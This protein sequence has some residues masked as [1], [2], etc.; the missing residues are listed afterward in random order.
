MIKTIT[1]SGDIYTDSRGKIRFVNGFNFKGVKRFYQIENA[2]TDIVRAFHGHKKEEKFVYV[3]LG[4]IIFCAVYIA[5]FKKP[6]KKTVVQRYILTHKKPQVIYVPPHFANGFRAL[7]KKT[8][9]IFYS[10]ASLEDSKKDDYRIPYDY[11]GTNIWQK[12]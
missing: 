5:D 3:A 4:S 11:W 6:S 2:N 9:V 10:T 8:K 1:Y 12:F 7:E